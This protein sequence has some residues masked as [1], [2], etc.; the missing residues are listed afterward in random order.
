MSVI[1]DLEKFDSGAFLKFL[2]LLLFITPGSA[3]IYHFH[4]TLLVNLDVLKVILL[5]MSITLPLFLIMFFTIGIMDT[6]I[7]SKNDNNDAE[8]MFIFTLVALIILDA[9]LYL[10]LLAAYLWELS[11]F[12]YMVGVLATVLIT[13]AILILTSLKTKRTIGKKLPKS[14]E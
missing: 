7:G 6:L 8:I 2:N 11:T 12:V 3:I 5:S 4:K 14:R 1:T 10:W 13:S 9:I